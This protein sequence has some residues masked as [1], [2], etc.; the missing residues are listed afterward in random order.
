M[1]ATRD[2]LTRDGQAYGRATAALQRTRDRLGESIR[3]AHAN[4]IGPAEITRL[5]GHRLTEKTVSRIIR[6]QD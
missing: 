1:D 4:G 2:R 6:E 5:I 3:A